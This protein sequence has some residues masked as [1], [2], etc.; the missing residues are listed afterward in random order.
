MTRI[1]HVITR[2]AGIDWQYTD[3]GTFRRYFKRIDGLSA[4]SVAGGGH[5]YLLQDTSF[6]SGVRGA[7]IVSCSALA[8]TGAV[9]TSQF[10]LSMYFSTSS[11]ATSF[12]LSARNVTGSTLSWPDISV[13]VELVVKI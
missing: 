12:S 7:D 1:R 5:A 4:S 11:E 9:S 3:D 8:N 2:P 6:P 10:A 13:Y